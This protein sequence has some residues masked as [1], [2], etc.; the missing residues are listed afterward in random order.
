MPVVAIEIKQS[1]EH[2]LKKV[3]IREKTENAQN[4]YKCGSVVTKSFFGFSY[5]GY[6]SLSSRKGTNTEK[7]LSIANNY[8]EATT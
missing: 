3:F 6:L 8:Y 5:R 7:N 4:G 2:S 1:R